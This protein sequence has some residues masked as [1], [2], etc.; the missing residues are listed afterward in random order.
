MT[1][2]L[3][4]TAPDEE[5][6]V[7][8]YMQPVV[9]TAAERST[10]DEL[11]FCVAFRVSGPDD[12]DVGLDEPVMQLEW[13]DKARNG[14]SALQN[15]KLSARDGHRRMLYLARHSVNVVMSDGSVANAD[16]LTTLLKPFRMAYEDDQIVRYVARYQ[17]G[18][19]YVTV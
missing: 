19:S 1:D 4:E 3:N 16:Y 17:L 5:D 18:L 13:F 12:P 10:N 7:A 14:M 6:F 9:R 2:L 15:A 11:P 8:C